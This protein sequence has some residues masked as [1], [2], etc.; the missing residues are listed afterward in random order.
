M[1]TVGPMTGSRSSTWARPVLLAAVLAVVASAGTACVDEPP[2]SGAPD[3]TVAGRVLT[4]VDPATDGRFVVGVLVAQTGPLAAADARVLSGIEAVAATG[5]GRDPASPGG[6]LALE[7]VDTESDLRTATEAAGRLLDRG[8]D[9]L[10]VGCDP[11]AARNAAVAAARTSRLVL[12]PCAAAGAAAT[13]EVL[14]TL[15]PDDETQGRVLAEQAIGAGLLRAAT[16]SEL[17][18]ADGPR[19]CRAFVARYQELGG[20]LVAELEQPLGVG[21]D[22]SAT[23]LGRLERPDVVVSCV[24]TSSVPVL[25]ATLRQ[26]GIES[27][28]LATTSADGAG[29][30][31]PTVAYLAPVPLRPPTPSAQALIDRGVPANGAALL[32]AYALDVLIG[33]AADAKAVDGVALAAALRGAGTAT[34]TDGIAFDAQQRL[35]LPLG[36]VPAIP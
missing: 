23:N 29:L 27:P 6:P 4:R 3:A 31:D 11:D 14:F 16:V 7:I 34:R 36:L 33:A 12:A 30:A 5:A 28:V 32:G 2:P 22:V 10:V 9:V 15:G 1:A 8:A 26:L 19:Q 24:T 17:A 13:N 35:V 20:R 18:P 25:V 21:A